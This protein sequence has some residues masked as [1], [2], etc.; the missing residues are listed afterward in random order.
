MSAF[1]RRR[2]DAR[3]NAENRKDQIYVSRI[4][5]VVVRNTIWH[6]CVTLV[7]WCDWLTHIRTAELH[8][9]WMAFAPVTPS[10]APEP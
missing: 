7:V 9:I 8:R 4:Y 1:A 6:H 3:A 2:P 5:F 10:E